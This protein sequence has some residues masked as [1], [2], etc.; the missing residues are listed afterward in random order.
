MKAKL[1]KDY[2]WLNKLINLR[3]VGGLHVTDKAQKKA[4][5]ELIADKFINS[6]TRKGTWRK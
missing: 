3:A 5:E 2:F 1:Y 6:L 4:W